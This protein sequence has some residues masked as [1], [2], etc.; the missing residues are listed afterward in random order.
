MDAG[1]TSILLAV[2][3]GIAAFFS[4]SETAFFALQS[5]KLHHLASSGSKNAQRIVR[6]KERP[7]RFLS[8]VLFGNNLCNT[9]ITA[10]A[11]TLAIS[12]FGQERQGLSVLVATA[13]VTVGITVL[14]ET[15]PKTLGAR[16]PEALSLAFAPLWSVMDK[17]LFPF[18]LG[19][20]LMSKAA[21]RPFGKVQENRPIVSVDELRTMVRM[22]ASEGTVQQ[23]QAEMIHRA[24]RFGDTRAQEIM[25]PRTE[26]VWVSRSVTFSEL[27]TVFA[28]GGHTRY[29][30]YDESENAVG[31]LH[32]KDVLTAYARGAVG[33]SDRLTGL[34]RQAHF[35]PETKPVDDLFTEMRS[36]GTQ[37][38]LLVNEYGALAG[39][40][41]MKQIVSEVVGRITDEESAEPLV[42]HLTD[43]TMEV[44]ASLRVGEA[45]ERLHL[46]IPEG[47]YDTVAG[48][49]LMKLGHIPSEGEEVSHD[50]LR[51]TVTGMRGVRVEKVRIERPAPAPQP[52]QAA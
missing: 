16:Y 37:M 19:L 50:S 8:T 33:P 1:L 18:A 22:G 44:D 31:I 34:V 27:M 10:L 11:T 15:A 20:Y 26:I 41:T 47:D 40:L 23:S 32:L 36:N 7:E 35:Y 6:L 13:A 9:A 46:G 49:I 43:R 2:F 14:G 25:T 30:V 12:L 24:F 3:L 39:L 21:T 52:G 29:P 42:R 5:V 28:D 48:F 51:L 38:V 4:I 17:L 45:N